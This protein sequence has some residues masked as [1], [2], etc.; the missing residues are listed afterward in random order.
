MALTEIKNDYIEVLPGVAFY[1][2][3][4]NEQV[5][6]V[7]SEEAL[8][9]LKRLH[10]EFEPQRQK[11][12][13]ARDER[14]KAYDA[15]ALPEYS[16]KNSEA[17]AGKWKVSPIPADLQRRRV[18]ITSP[19][20]SAR[21]VINMLSRNEEGYRADMAMLDFEDSM[22]PSWN[23][24][25]NG[26]HN[27]I[28]AV[29]GTLEDRKKMPDGTEKVYKLDRNDMAGIMVRVRGIHLNE[30]NLLING[31][32]ISAGLFDL[33]VCFF[34]TAKKLMTEGKTP[35]YYVPKCEHFMEARWW[36]E[37]FT[38]LESALEIAVGNLKATFLIETLP[39][40]FQIEEILY[41]I[42]EHAAGMNVGRWDKI[43]SDIKVL[44][45]HKDRIMADRASI[46]MQSPWMMNYAKRLIKICHERGA[47]AIGGMS[48]FT[49]GKDA[50]AREKQSAK[51]LEDKRFEASIGHDGCWVSHPYFIGIAMQAFTKDNQ[52]GS[53]LENFDKYSDILPQSIGP[54]TLEG[55]RKNIRVGIAYMRGWQEDLGCIA[56]DDLM[57]DLATMEISRVQVWQWL[58]HGTKLDDG[59]V[60]RPELVREVFD[61]EL[62]KINSEVR[63]TMKGQKDEMIE[64]ALRQFSEAKKAAEEVF[65]KKEFENFLTENSYIS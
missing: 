16:D 9:L 17:V 8:Q 62:K 61:S 55:L 41:E 49:P 20:N 31:E 15:G 2:E 63:E 42:R 19:I 56:W 14:Q 30:I 40:A 54:K 12:L 39:A 48:A 43:F 13:M 64:E 46:T 51:V 35:K 11:L 45:N 34:H 50:D 1:H 38:A 65:L 28:G 10:E 59:T 24:V 29:D 21:M 7:F 44:K 23:N 32:A 57:E 4:W 6:S 25:L 18:E 22:K 33:A 53:L 60:V 27:L 5:K 26:F 3:S 52:T 58:H 36:N 37:L 47:F